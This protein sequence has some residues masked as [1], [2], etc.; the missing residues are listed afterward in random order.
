MTR[1]I[2]LDPATKT[3]F[4][5]LDESGNVLLAKE[6]SGVSGGSSER[7]IRTLHDE[8]YRHLKAGDRIAVEWFALDAQDTNKTSSG[9]NWAARMA[10]DRVADGEIISP[11]PGDVKA[12]VGVD[13]WEGTPKRKGVGGRTRKDSK[14]VKKEIMAAVEVLYGFVPQT[15]NIAD[16]FVIAKIGL[17]VER[18][19]HGFT[20]GL[21]G[22]PE[23]MEIIQ[24]LAYPEEHKRKKAEEKKAAAARKKAKAAKKEATT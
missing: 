24:R 5:A 21:L 3:G 16:A 14:T 10:A 11:L 15:D 6:I 7:R 4:V 22:T 2:G 20:I 13:A 23:Q 12:W 1:Y 8:V 17:A 9:A 19:K 18:Y